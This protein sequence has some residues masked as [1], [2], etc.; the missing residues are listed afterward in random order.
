MGQDGLKERE[1]ADLGLS[2][3]PSLSEDGRRQ[4]RRRDLQGDRA[5]QADSREMLQQ[6]W[7]EAISRNHSV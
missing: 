7:D 2:E 6:D 5:D 4:R 3:K 1:K